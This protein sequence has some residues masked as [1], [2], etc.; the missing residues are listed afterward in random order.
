MR[1]TVPNS[2]DLLSFKSSTSTD[3]EGQITPLGL[4]L[5]LIKRTDEL[6]LRSEST[7]ILINLI[8]SL[9]SASSTSPNEDVERAKEAVLEK[10]EIVEAVSEQVRRSGKYPVLVNEGIV[11]L[12]LL[13]GNGEKGGEYRS[14]LC[15]RELSR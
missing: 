11:A 13:S 12:S 2:L 7:R 8:R 1:K 6:Q 5:A 14:T 15:H 3:Q 4:I 10:K 9:F